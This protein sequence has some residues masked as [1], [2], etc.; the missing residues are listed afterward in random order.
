MTPNKSRKKTEKTVRKKTSVK[1]ASSDLKLKKRKRSAVK[2]RAKK[3]HKRGLRKVIKKRSLFYKVKFLIFLIIA[4]IL[5][6]LVTSF[7]TKPKSIPFVSNKVE[8]FL[9]NKL[10]RKVKI[11]KSYI[12][13]IPYLGLK[14]TINDVKISYFN[15][16][17]VADNSFLIPKIEGE[18]SI[19]NLLLGRVNLDEVKII[20]PTINIDNF[21][22][23]YKD[24]STNDKIQATL[25]EPKG[26]NDISLI[27][28]ILSSMQDGGFLIRNFTIKNAKLL[29][30]GTE[31]SRKILI[32]ESVINTIKRNGVFYMAANS[33]ANFNLQKKDVNFSSNCQLSSKIG[34]KCNLILK[35]F[36]VNSIADISPEISALNQIN[37]IMN[38]KAS[39]SVKNGKMSNILFEAN[40]AKGSFNFLNFFGQELDFDD[41]YVSGDYD[42]KIGMLNLSDIK[43]G[44]KGDKHSKTK[45]EM[46]LLVSGI[47]ENSS[48]KSDFYIK[49]KDVATNDLEKY[50]P[51]ALSQNDI[52]DWVISHISGGIIKTAYAR[53]S[54]TD[55]NLEDIN[56]Q[57]VLKGV[58]LKYDDDDYFPKITNINAIA[59]FDYKTMKIDIATADVLDSK[60]NNALVTIDD[61][62]S[63]ITKLKIY[64]NL[65]GKGSDLLKHINNNSVFSKKI[66]GHFNGH[67]D[68]KFNII[69][70]ID[71]NLELRDVALDVKSKIVNFNSPNITGKLDLKVSKNANSNNFATNI[72][73]NNA[74]V[75]LPILGLSKKSN[76]NSELDFDLKVVSDNKIAIN[77][78]LLWHDNKK[79][80]NFIGNIQFDIDPFKFGNFTLKS[81]NFS[82]NNYKI[83]YNSEQEKLVIKGS[84]LSLANFLSKKS[85]KKFGKEQLLK[86]SQIQV[87]LNKIDLLYNKYLQDF[88][89]FFNC[90]KG[91]C[92]KGVIKAG[93]DNKH[94][95]SLNLEKDIKENHSI[96][97]GNISNIGYLIE[98]L[99]FSNTISANNAKVNIIN[100]SLDNK[101]L[102]EGEITIDDKFTI[103]ENATVKKLSNDS[104]FAKIKDSIFSNQKTIFD[105]LNLKFSLHDKKLNLESLVANNYKV[106]ITAKGNI[107]LAD[108]SYEIKG[109]IV[110]GF[111][112]NNLF[113]IGNIPLVGDV[114]SNILTGGE[115]GGVFGIRYQYVKNADDSEPQFETN[116]V[117][118]FVP[119][120]I[121]NLFDLI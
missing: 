12:S 115:G 112:I 73:F 68:S 35:N 95:I 69:L 23:V 77:N 102:F 62:H 37:A 27:F 51:I 22:E 54:M 97:S 65:K 45:L 29:L 114:I 56:S 4:L 21:K 19:F 55:D 67:A 13:I 31:F 76:I 64:G 42:S 79:L 118:A 33:S 93:H 103:Y 78:I 34:I 48:K 36:A 52:R 87:T 8:S 100:K 5:A 32:K 91:L 39:F 80:A 20:N 104:L 81:N 109:M 28:N 105:S 2:K 66:E 18:I 43:V 47:G 58:N 117:S 94:L 41:L 44:F 89:L 120:T 116:K 30:N 108:N 6:Y 84:K 7:A 3:V 60:I 46:S 92:D 53:F 88:Y 26:E 71:S 121:K 119:T 96:I 50:W 11:G 17:D 98:A 59:N 106:G 61:F 111:I 1:K 90:N 113:G 25:A 74:S 57:L 15:F 38:A 101:A 14:V 99:G 49:L 107:N 9:Q 10:G 24:N 72:N 86:I 16:A 75:K 82:N 63:D 110:P 83:S 85:S 40:S 70:P